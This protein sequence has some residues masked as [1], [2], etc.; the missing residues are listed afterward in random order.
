[1]VIYIFIFKIVN[2]KQ[3]LNWF[4]SAYEMIIKVRGKEHDAKVNSVC[5]ILS[6]QNKLVKCEDTLKRIFYL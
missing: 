2:I 1:M 4:I 6:L 3:Q 5:T